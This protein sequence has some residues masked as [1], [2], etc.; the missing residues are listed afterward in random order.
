M[1]YLSNFTLTP[2]MLF[3]QGIG[4]SV[5]VALAKEGANVVVNYV[6]SSSKVHAESVAKVIEGT[7]SKA[8]VVQADLASVEALE[9][10]VQKT[11]EQFGKID[12][13][14]SLDCFPIRNSCD[15]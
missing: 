11:V 13:L 8:L 6:S 4:A 10:L 2:D 12:I 7:G 14:V 9:L 15:Q 3:L 5:A 1:L